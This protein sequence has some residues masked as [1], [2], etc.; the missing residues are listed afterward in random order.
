[1]CKCEVEKKK[2]VW[3]KPST[4]LMQKSQPQ[5]KLMHCPQCSYFDITRIKTGI[6]I[7]KKGRITPDLFQIANYIYRTNNC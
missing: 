6:R 3:N 4:Q 1:M 7:E 5:P 2:L